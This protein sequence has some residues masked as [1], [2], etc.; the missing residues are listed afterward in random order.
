MINHTP[1]SALTWVI[2]ACTVFQRCGVVIFQVCDSQWPP[3]ILGE[4]ALAANLQEGDNK[5]KWALVT[6]AVHFAV[7]TS[8][9]LLCTA[10][11]AKESFWLALLVVNGPCHRVGHEIERCNDCS[12][13]ENKHVVM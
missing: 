5:P 9:K 4:T 12:L 2:S 7:A 1:H 8:S 13:R 3:V 10:D 6:V 11:K